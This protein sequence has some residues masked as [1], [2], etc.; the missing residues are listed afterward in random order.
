[1]SPLV[2]QVPDVGGGYVL[3][4]R[5]AEKSIV[6]LKNEHNV[7]PMDGAGL[8]SVV[9]I[10][11]HADVGVL[12]GGGSAQV[13]APGGSVIPPPPAQPGMNPMANF[14]RRQVW[15]PSSPL[16]AF[17]AK[18]PSSKVSFIPGDDL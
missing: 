18:L 8:H 12:P 3:A 2:K 16:R 13:D 7:L 1:D 6:L 15:L 10:G 4:Q 5:L 14:S 9:L 11:G 17:A